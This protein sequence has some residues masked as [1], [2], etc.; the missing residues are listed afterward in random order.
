MNEST[1]DVNLEEWL[2]KVIKI[3]EGKWKN[4]EHDHRYKRD[5]PAF[6]G[7]NFLNDFNLRHLETKAR[8]DESKIPKSIK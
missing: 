7:E 8:R 1:Q 2:K 3:W 5:L 6:I 4:F